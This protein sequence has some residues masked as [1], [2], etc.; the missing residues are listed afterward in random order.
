MY[1]HIFKLF[2]QF[3]LIKKS[4]RRETGSPWWIRL[5]ARRLMLQFDFLRYE[6]IFT[7]TVD[8]RDVRTRSASDLSSLS[9]RVVIKTS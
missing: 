9:S 1:F 8:V 2:F 6:G 4:P 5:S 3:I 7:V